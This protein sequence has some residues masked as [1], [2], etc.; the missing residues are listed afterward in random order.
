MFD[1]FAVGQFFKL[2]I[3]EEDLKQGVIINCFSNGG[4]K[5]KVVFFDRDG[6]VRIVEESQ[7][8]RKKNT[9]AS[10]FSKIFCHYLSN[11]WNR[12]CMSG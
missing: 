10:T 9:E 5:F 7:V 4:D 3:T 1:I 2:N 12:P 8:K 11:V 6:Q